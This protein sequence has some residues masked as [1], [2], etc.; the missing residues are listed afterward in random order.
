MLIVVVALLWLMMLLPLI[1]LLL[2][3]GCRCWFSVAGV[4]D[5]LLVVVGDV[6]DDVVVWGGVN[7]C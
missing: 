2:S 6:G 4:V 5:A 3:C 7:A 1:M